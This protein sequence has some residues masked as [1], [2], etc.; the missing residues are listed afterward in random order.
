MRKVKPRKFEETEHLCCHCQGKVMKLI[1]GGASAG[2]NAYYECMGCG[3]G[4]MGMSSGS[5]TGSE[6]PIWGKDLANLHSVDGQASCN[7]CSN[8][9]DYTLL[10]GSCGLSVRLCPDCV[11]SLEEQLK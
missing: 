2:G 7:F 5:V 1:D 11:E 6:R 9:G 10:R 8:F 3:T 4:D